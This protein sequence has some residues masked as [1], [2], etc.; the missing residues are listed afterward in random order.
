[1]ALMETTTTAKVIQV[2]FG[3]LSFEQLSSLL[4]LPSAPSR[5]SPVYETSI[6]SKYDRSLSNK[7]IA[8]LVRADLKAMLPGVKASVCL[9]SGGISIAVTI[10]SVPAGVDADAAL[11]TAKSLLLAYRRSTTES[12]SD[13]SNTNFHYDVSFSSEL[14]ASMAVAS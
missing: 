10:K 2:S 11:E 1:M 14:R 13:Y 7:A 9:T 5:F 4:P 3:S 6:G 8:A 12:A